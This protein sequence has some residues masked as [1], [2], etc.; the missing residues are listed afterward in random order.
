MAYILIDRAFDEL[1]KREDVPLDSIGALEFRYLPMFRSRKKALVL[2]TLMT[3]QPRLFMDAVCAVFKPA[4]R[5]ADAP[6]EGA[7]KLARASYDLLT[8][9]RVI[10]GQTDSGIDEQELIAWCTEVRRIATE[11]DREKIADQR[12]GT[13]LAHAPLS[14]KD[15]AWPDEAVRS[16]VDNYK[17]NWQYRFDERIAEKIDKARNKQ[18]SIKYDSSILAPFHKLL[19]RWKARSMTI[20]IALIAFYNPLL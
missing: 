12:I 2:H 18:A 5:E 16:I 15:G 9:I 10:P 19:D 13:I 11:V 20:K 14:T 7:E 4:N 3:K 17:S 6:V 8:G 1:R